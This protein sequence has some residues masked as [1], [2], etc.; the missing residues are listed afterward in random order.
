MNNK[1]D[2]SQFSKPAQRRLGNARGK[3]AKAEFTKNVS[4]AMAEQDERNERAKKG[5]PQS[6]HGL[7][8]L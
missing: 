4:K 5:M 1:Y 7:I 2:S 8:Q 6:P 3:K